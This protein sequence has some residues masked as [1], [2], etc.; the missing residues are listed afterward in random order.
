MIPAMAILRIGRGRRLPV[1]LP[2]FLLWPLV[3]L[4]LLL[5]ALAGPL[6]DRRSEAGRRLLAARLGIL[7][8]FRLSGLSVDARGSDGREVRIRL[9]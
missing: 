5:V 3:L 4:A 8:L 1:P 7:A 9:V 2:L 6:A